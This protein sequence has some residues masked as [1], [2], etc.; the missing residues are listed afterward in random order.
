MENF[1]V[2]VVIILL[3]MVCLGYFNEKVTKLTYEISLMLFSIVIG[4]VLLGAEVCVSGETASEILGQFQFIN[5]ERFLTEGVLCFMLFAGSC[6]MRLRSFKTYAR[7][8]TLLSIGATLL[9]AVFYGLL[10]YGAGQLL[11]LGLSLPVCLMF[12]SI[13]APTDP[14]AATSILKKFN[15]P[16]NIGFII[17]GESLLNDG[18][19][20]ALFVCFSG[21]VTAEANQGFFTVMIRELAGAVAVGLVVTFLIF[22]M[23]KRTGDEARRIFASLLAVSAAYLICEILGFSGAIASVVCGVMFSALRNREA[24]QGREMA[25]EKFDTFWE[26]ADTLLN[27][28]LYVMLG[29]SFLRILTMPQVLLLSVV[30]IAANL[31]GRSCSVGAMSL[32]AGKLPDGYDRKNFVALLTWGGLRGGLCVALAMSTSSML[33]ETVYHIVLGGTYAIV[34][35]T[36]IIQGMTMKSVYRHIEGNLE[37]HAD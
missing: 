37:R 25:L 7:T 17:E 33:P 14:I 29:L 4:A 5:L 32:F 19:G 12:G 9:G 23:F 34:F 28:A 15:L 31:I 22:P 3:L 36:T 20:V 2:K 6:H 10:F 27:S 18:V 16:K 11:G 8:I 26:M 21:M 24:E 1:L 30:A 35:F 13:T